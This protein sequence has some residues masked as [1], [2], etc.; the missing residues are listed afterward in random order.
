[1]RAA[2]SLSAAVMVVVVSALVGGLFGGRALATQDR[3]AERYKVFSNALAAIEANYVEEVD[4]DRLVYGAIN[5]MLQTL[6]PHSS[7]MDPRTYSQMRERQEGRYYG[8][9]ITIQVQDGDITVMALFDGAPAHQEGIRRGD[10]I[11]EIEGESASGWTSDQAVR[12]LRGPKGSPVN[13]AIR[14]QGYDELIPLEVTRDE[15]SIPTIRG[16]FMVNASTGYVR[17][18][19]FSE[20]TDDDLGLALEDLAGQGMQQLLLDLRDNPGGPLDQAIRV[21]NRFLPRGDMI[22]YTRGRIPN[23]DQDYHASEESDFTDLPLVVL[24]NR[25]SAS[26]SEIVA[27]AIQDHDRGLIVGE[28]TFGKALVQSIYRVSEGAGLA[29]TTA[30]YYTPSGRLIQRPWDG[31]FDEYL[32]YSMRDQEA[33]RQHSSTDLKYTDAGRQVYSAG[34]IEPDE[35]MAGPVEGFD[36]TPIG[37]RLFARQAFPRY[38]QKYSAIG[39]TRI[40]E[41]GR[42]RVLVDRDFDMTD[43]IVDDFMQFLAQERVAIDVDALADDAAFVRAMIRYTI[44]LDLFGE[45]DARRHLVEVD[46]QAK[47]ALTLFDKAEALTRLARPGQPVEP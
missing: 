40:R 27:G 10:V 21:A 42:D 7:F 2:Q 23:S 24:V 39:D 30:R 44:D 20:T 8:L 14:R 31:T 22:V 16:A 35:F 4:T 13:I 17:L 47:F 19:D 3:V 26:A 36:P 46:P 38:A 25:N 37:R 6:D 32:M 29:L 43:E 45:V 33:D 28:T 34:G 41:Q 5:G 1:M 18:R 15:V 9:G 11:A 12:R